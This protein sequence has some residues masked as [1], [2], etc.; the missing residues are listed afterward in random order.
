MPHL[1]ALDLPGGQEFVDA[2]RREWDAGH[3]VMPVDQRLPDPARRALFDAMQPDAV[4]DTSGR[5]SLDSNDPGRRDALM[6]LEDG[7]ALLMATSGSTGSPKG[8]V[9]THDAVRASALATSRRLGTGPDDT[10]LA[11]LPLAHVGG[12]S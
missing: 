8:A 4:L 9:L 2:L 12:L 3:V 1:V 11:C 6:A 5:T 10:W 7:D